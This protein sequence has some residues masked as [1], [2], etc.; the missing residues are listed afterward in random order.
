M[1]GE[2]SDITDSILICKFAA[3]AMPLRPSVRRSSV[4]TIPIIATIRP[5]PSEGRGGEGGNK[6]SIRQNGARVSSTL[7]PN[8]SL[9]RKVYEGAAI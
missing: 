5:N 8:Q 7:T 6:L 3:N 1:G 2:G 4:R 9:T